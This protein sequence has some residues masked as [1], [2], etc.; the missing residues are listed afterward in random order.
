M[1]TGILIL[2]MPCLTAPDLDRQRGTGFGDRLIIA[3]KNISVVFS[4]ALQ[5]KIERT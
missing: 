3:L 4:K 2:H 5:V 1:S